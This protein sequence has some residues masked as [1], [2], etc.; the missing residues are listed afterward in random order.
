MPRPVVPM[1]SLRAASMSLSICRYR[2][3]TIWARSLMNT[4][5]CQSM[6]RSQHIQLGEQGLRVYGHAG[7]QDDGLV[8]VQHTGWNQV[9]GKL[10][11]A[12]DGMAGIGAAGEPHD[13]LGVGRQVI[14][15]L[16][17]ALIA[18][19]GPYHYYVHMCSLTCL[20]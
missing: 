12:H 17:F 1:G 10:L 15:Y 13:Y 18:P 11:V 5:P 9:Q 2:G 8:R 6:P 4:L 7:A 19:L 14:D 3:S 16:A 20:E